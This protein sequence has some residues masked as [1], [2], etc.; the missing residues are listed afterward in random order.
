MKARCRNLHMSHF[1]HT[2][3]CRA[4]GQSRVIA[5]VVLGITSTWCKISYMLQVMVSSQNEW[6]VCDETFADK[7]DNN[8]GCFF[9]NNE[10]YIN[11]LNNFKVHKFCQNPVFIHK[12]HTSSR[13]YLPQVHR[14]VIQCVNVVLLVISPPATPPPSHVSPTETAQTWAWR[15]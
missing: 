3:I 4:N 5:V 6:D 10:K 11:H 13:L 2:V 7:V 8:L 1:S 15:H 12:I 9:L 14:W